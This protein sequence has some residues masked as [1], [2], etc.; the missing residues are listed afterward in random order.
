MSDVFISYA[1]AT[2]AQAHEIAELLRGLGFTVWRDDQLPAHRPY[3][4]V[5]EERLRA[6]MAV[7]VVWSADAVRSQWVRAEAD[8]AR[9]GDKLVQIKLDRTALPLP[10]NHIQCTDL[11]NWQGDGSNPR[12]RKVVDSV[13]LLTGTKPVLQPG[14]PASASATAFAPHAPG[15]SVA[16]H[17]HG[18]ALPTL[19]LPGKP[20][21]AVLPFK[22]LTGGI[23]HDYFADG[24]VEEIATVLSRFQTLFVIGGS[25][26]RSYR[27]SSQPL[28]AI[29]RELGVRYLLDGSVRRAANRVRISVTLV[30]GIAG[31]Q[32]WADRFDENLE[33][34]FEL[35]DKVANAVASVIDSTIEAVEARR[36]EQRPTSS[37]DA[38]ECYLRANAAAIGWDREKA[39]EA[40]EWGKRALQLDPGYA[41]AAV[42]V[43]FLNAA[44]YLSQWSETPEHNHREAQKYLA[45]ALRLGG[46]DP[47]VLGYGAGTL[48]AMGEDTATAQRLVDRA[49]E[50]NPGSSLTLFWAGW[51]D[52][53]AG[54]SESGLAH[55]DA[56]LRL[57]PRSARRPFQLTGKGLCLF[58]LQ[59]LAEATAVLS[60][61]EQ[62]RPDH[63]P[64]IVGL[65]VCF[66]FA[67]RLDEARALAARLRPLGGAERVLAVLQDPA[68]REA[69]RAGLAML[70]VAH[71]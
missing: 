33:D 18:A 37:P 38:Y 21:I 17:H 71:A 55:F 6:A 49:M 4:D 5:I 15:P 56:S 3:A 8:M 13:A 12:W 68:Q 19:H 25:T 59:R 69:V 54:R 11:S 26:S 31:E 16:D 24:I 60:E 51:A 34:V 35:Q 28:P 7:V 63:T 57:D 70:E 20:S 44:A 29:A 50:L 58:G 65:C 67:G 66:A 42:L 39:L 48:I 1:S 43:A 45:M 36:A 41:W 52:V 30:D 14:A 64:A 61:A 27:D 62:Q 40:I 46:D 10:F 22:D 32:I 2:E 53:A 9:Q 23:T 47:Y